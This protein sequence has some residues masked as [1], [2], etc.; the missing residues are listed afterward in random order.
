MRQTLLLMALL[1]WTHYIGQQHLHAT[2]S[3]ASGSSSH[4]HKA[5]LG[6]RRGRLT[7]PWHILLENKCHAAQAHKSSDHGQS[8]Y[9]NGL[10]NYL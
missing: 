10:F 4:L 2:V 9:I 6:L 5:E 1:A 7:R 8:T 3:A